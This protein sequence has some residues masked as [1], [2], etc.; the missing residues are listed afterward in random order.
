MYEMLLL[1]PLGDEK[2]IDVRIIDNKQELILARDGLG[3]P[4]LK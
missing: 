2:H 1:L 3:G 4:V